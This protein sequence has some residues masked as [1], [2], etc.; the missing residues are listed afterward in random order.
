MINKR[1][2]FHLAAETMRE[3]GILVVVFGPLDA[4]FQEEVAAPDTLSG[5]VVLA[6]F[7]IVIGIMIEAGD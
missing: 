7:A 3:I 1:K 2:A 6:L 5:I 4:F